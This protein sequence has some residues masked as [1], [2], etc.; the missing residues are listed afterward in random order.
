MIDVAL[1]QFCAP[2]VA[3]ETIQRIVQ[4]ESAGDIYAVNVNGYGRV[5]TRAL[6]EAV[7]A[8]ERLIEQ[9]YSVDL[10]LMQINSRHLAQL[11]LTVRQAFEPCSNLKAGA[12]ILEEAY[13]EAAGLLGPGQQALQA[14]LSTYNT[15]DPARGLAN[16]YV[17]QVYAVRLTAPAPVSPA[18]PRAA[19]AYNASP[20]LVLPTKDLN[21]AP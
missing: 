3:V 18:P 12:K 15:G 11:N 8:A 19:V 4:V 5:H 17:A 10:G 14:A 1:I 2:H 20:T 16:G 21:H 7:S 6:Q 9:G 13:R